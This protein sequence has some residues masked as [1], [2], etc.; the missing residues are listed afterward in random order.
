MRMRTSGCHTALAGACFNTPYGWAFF[1]EGH[2]EG[3]QHYVIGFPDRK[4]AFILMTNSDNGESIF[5]E[6]VED[7]TGV[8]IPWVWER[9]YA[10]SR[11]RKAIPGSARHT[12]F[13]GGIQRQIKSD[14]Q[15]FQRTLGGRRPPTS[16][17]PIFMQKTTTISS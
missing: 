2:D 3:W 1:K 6:L 4:S 14:H 15:P 17:R 9:I 11:D 13:V 16:Q 8:T 5:K 10:L 12:A 7:L